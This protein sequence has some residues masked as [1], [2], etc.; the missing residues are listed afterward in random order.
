[1]HQSNYRVQELDVDCD[2]YGNRLLEEDARNGLNFYDDFNILEAVKE[3][4]GNGYNKH[5]YANLLRSEH[6]PFNFFIPLC[7][8]FEYAKNVFNEHLNITIEEILD[9]KIEYSPEPSKVY[10]DDKTSF[11]ASIRY[12]NSNYQIGLL[13]IEVKY[14]ERGYPLNKNSKEDMDINNPISRYHVVAEKSGLFIEGAAN[15]LILDDCRQIWRNH[16]L[17]ESM[18]QNNDISHFSS[19][20]LYP[21]GNKHFSKVIPEYHNLLKA[22]RQKSMIGITYEEFFTALGNHTTDVR[23]LNWIDYLTKRYLV[24]YE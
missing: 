5:L 24:D 2:E 10:L 15:Q 22:D 16:F 14:T 23:Y 4:Y 19:I 3:R 21:A 20:T 9:I 7:S 1:L 11:D 12:L 17:G 13:G 8:N 6:I 18:K